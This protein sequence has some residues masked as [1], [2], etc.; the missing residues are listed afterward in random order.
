MDK[1]ED[2]VKKSL[3]YSIVD[4][5]F[6]S[7]MVGFGE[8]F[9]SAFAVFLK[10]TNFQLGILGSL[11]QTVGSISQLF[12]NRLI[13]YFNSRKRFVCASVF[14]EALMYIPI[15]LV[16]FFGTMRVWH[17]IL[18]LCMYWTFG[19]IVSPAWSSWMGDLVSEKERGRYFGDRNRIAGLVWFVTLLIGGYILQ[20]YSHGMRNGY[21]GFA[22]IFMIAFISRVISFIYLSK[23][24]EPVYKQ[25]PEA[26]FTFIDFLKQARSR[27]YGR[28]VLFLCSMNFAVYIAGPFFTAYMLNDLK[29]DY[30]TFTI[31]T[32]A[33]IIAKYA[34]MPYWGRLADK[35]G[36]RKLL[37]MSS[38]LMPLCPLLWI[39]STNILYLIII[40]IYGGIAWAAFEISSFDFIFDATTPQKRATCVSYFNVLNGIFIFIGGLTGA[41]IV[42][43][44]T[45]FWSKY[46]L[47]FILSFAARYLATAFFVQKLKEVRKVE[48]ISYPRLL[49]R[50]IPIGPVVNTIHKM[51][52]INGTHRK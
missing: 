20:E 9:F 48:E 21:I 50:T 40:E 41:L 47:V 32:A 44:N 13:R 11:P 16:Y 10:A 8:S 25:V 15:A 26:D 7:S 27:N 22:I 38:F 12:S 39:F 1:K 42:K 46:H 6:Y 18:F 24:Y 43:Y 5:A 51:H 23:K 3:K 52:F 49:F 35:Y 4:G 29:M 33:S 28:F 37:V 34:A 2:K 17:L 19:M 30:M 36:T 31:V 45:L 14:L